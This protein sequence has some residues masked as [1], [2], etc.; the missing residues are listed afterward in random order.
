MTTSV[1]VHNFPVRCLSACP[2]LFGKLVGGSSGLPLI[3]DR[4]GTKGHQAIFAL[5]TM[6]LIAA[7]ASAQGLITNASFTGLAK[8]W[9]MDGADQAI[10]SVTNADGYTDNTSLRYEVAAKTDGGPITQTFDCTVYTDYVITAALK[11][12]GRINPLVRAVEPGRA[13]V[14]AG[15]IARREMTWTRYTVRFNSGPATKLQV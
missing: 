10:Y 15:M 11:S 2:E 14:L 7:A 13:R 5:A 4:R 9:Q 12:N 3:G 6:G 8:G 1:P